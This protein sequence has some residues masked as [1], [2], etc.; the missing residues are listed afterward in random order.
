MLPLIAFGLTRRLRDQKTCLL[1]LFAL[2]PAFGQTSP[3][4]LY[5]HDTTGV[6]PDAP[7]PSLYQM[8]STAVGN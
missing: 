8:A 4:T 7:L 5:I 1:L 2:A 6:L 3:F